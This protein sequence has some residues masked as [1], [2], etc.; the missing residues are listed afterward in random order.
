[1]TAPDPFR[2]SRVAAPVTV[3]DAPLQVPDAGRS[4]LLRAG[5]RAAGRKR[6]YLRRALVM[7]M[8]LGAVGL[9]AAAVASVWFRP[10][11][12]A[13]LLYLVHD[14]IWLPLRGRLWV[15]PFPGGLVWL[16]PLLG[17]SALALVE[18]L[19]VASPLRRVQVAGIGLAL[20]GRPAAALVLWDAALR[21]FGGRAG[22]VRSVATELRDA[23]RMAVMAAIEAGT[24]AAPVAALVHRETMVLRLS[25]GTE[26]DLVSAL[27]VLCLARLAGAVGT[28]ALADGIAQ[29]AGVAATQWRGLAE[30]C[31]NGV[32][33]LRAALAAAEVLAGGGTDAAMAAVQT[34]QVALAAG[35]QG[36][37][38]GPGQA[39]GLAWVDVWG[40]VRAGRDPAA[41]RVLARAETLIA[42]EF[43]AAQAE[44]RIRR[45]VTPGL[46]AEAFGDHSGP[47][48]RGEVFA[49]T[50]VDLRPG[51][52]SR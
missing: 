25:E 49:R 27:E 2:L 14:T 47:R 1:M 31:R 8:L 4:T 10:D 3:S 11:G 9:L 43:W 15:A 48:G 22:Q 26:A 45:P 34:L 35:E 20:N 23:S 30:D 37:A 16:V 5:L 32:P 24:H 38:G 29:K 13:V 51:G 17:L 19:G 7:A 52:G 50:G 6:P 12:P 41:A 42:F 36:Q 44:A 33:D 40:R 46:L 39:G 28:A 18:F 21:R